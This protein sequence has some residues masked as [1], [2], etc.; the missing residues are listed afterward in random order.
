MG[1]EGSQGRRSPWRE[2]KKK[3]PE[4]FTASIRSGACVR[5]RGSSRK[6]GGGGSW[7]HWGA[8]RRGRREMGHAG[9]AKKGGSANKKKSEIG[10]REG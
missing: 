7:R 3:G 5:A 10:R 1:R 4:Y 2:G 9:V 8:G 6:E